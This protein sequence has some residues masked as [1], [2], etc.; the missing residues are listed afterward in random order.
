MDKVAR[1]FASVSC[2]LVL[3]QHL[4]QSLIIKL[5]EICSW[6][7]VCR[8]GRAAVRNEWENSWCSLKNVYLKMESR[9]WLWCGL[10]SLSSH[11]YI[12]ELLCRLWIWESCGPLARP[13]ADRGCCFLTLWGKRVSCVLVTY[14]GERLSPG[15]GLLGW[16]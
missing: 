4:A 12:P 15:V 3:Q 8:L 7:E 1:V 10:V 13:L 2:K 6:R 11:S 16:A 14:R 5:I 9:V